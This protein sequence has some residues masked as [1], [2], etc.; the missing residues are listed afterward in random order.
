M[1]DTPLAGCAHGWTRL[2]FHPSCRPAIRSA[3]P[4]ESQRRNRRKRV[5]PPRQIQIA[6]RL[7][8]HEGPT[9]TTLL[10]ALRGWAPVLLPVRQTTHIVRSVVACRLHGGRPPTFILIAL[11]PPACGT[12]Q[13]GIKGRT[14]WRCL[15]YRCFP[16]TLTAPRR[17]TPHGGTLLPASRG[18]HRASSQASFPPTQPLRQVGHWAGAATPKPPPIPDA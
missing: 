2:P 5:Q 15:P 17:K 9:S 7:R 12:L 13:R 6:P 18:S 1:A 4:A 11:A 8:W 14:I 10:T 16:V 3:P